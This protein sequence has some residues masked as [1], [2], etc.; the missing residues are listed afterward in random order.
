MREPS[1]EVTYRNGKALAAYYYLPRGPRDVAHVT[2]R[3]ESGLL[4]DYSKVGKPIGVEITVPGK[5]SVAVMNRLLKDLG[6]SPVRR[7]E[8]APLKAA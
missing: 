8:L 4:V 7:S 5:I 3:F 2:R 1:L 6:L